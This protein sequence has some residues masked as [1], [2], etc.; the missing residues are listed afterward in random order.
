MWPNHPITFARMSSPYGVCVLLSL[1]MHMPFLVEQDSY[2]YC[3]R[4]CV[5]LRCI[6]M[7][8]VILGTALSMTPCGFAPLQIE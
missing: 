3:G 7:G 8:S 6:F 1:S 4:S 5:E 2:C